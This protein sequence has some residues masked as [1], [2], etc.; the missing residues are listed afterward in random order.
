MFFFFL[1]PLSM[2]NVWVFTTWKCAKWICHLSWLRE[3]NHQQSLNQTQILRSLCFGCFVFKEISHE[4]QSLA[5]GRDGGCHLFHSF[6]WPSMLFTRGC[7]QF[8]QQYP[9]LNRKQDPCFRFL[10]SPGGRGQL[11]L[12]AIGLLVRMMRAIVT[13]LPVKPEWLINYN[14][15]KFFSWMIS[16]I[17]LRQAIKES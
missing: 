7:L 8:G 4:W 10:I 2:E 3:A 17:I 13:S 12:F 1:L 16:Q 11:R 9:P 14:L 15:A 5:N 6:F